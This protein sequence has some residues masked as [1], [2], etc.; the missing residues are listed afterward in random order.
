LVFLNYLRFNKDINSNKVITGTD[1]PLNRQKFD[2]QEIKMS[3]FAGG[4]GATDEQEACNLN[5]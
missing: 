3:E 1:M 5:Q 4:K 2:F